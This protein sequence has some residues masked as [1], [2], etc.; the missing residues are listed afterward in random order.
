[1]SRSHSS[2]RSMLP[3]HQYVLA[4]GP[5]TCAQAASLASTAARAS[6]IASARE[7]VVVWTCR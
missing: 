7:S 1:M 2:A 6:S 4:T 5:A 3:S